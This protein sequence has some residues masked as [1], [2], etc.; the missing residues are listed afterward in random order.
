MD[1]KLT[2]EEVVPSCNHWLW[3]KQR[4]LRASEIESEWMNVKI[5]CK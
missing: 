2:K 3:T 5:W 4:L 1:H